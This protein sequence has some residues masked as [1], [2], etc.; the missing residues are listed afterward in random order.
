MMTA[1]ERDGVLVVFDEN[2]GVWTPDEQAAAEIAEAAD[3]AAA[4]VEMCQ[5]SPMRGR[6]QD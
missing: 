6:W 3:P 2:G 5:S 4:A 1:E